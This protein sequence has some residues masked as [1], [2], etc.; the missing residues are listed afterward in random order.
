MDFD[1]LKPKQSFYRFGAERRGLNSTQFSLREP[2][3]DRESST[4]HGAR[5]ST[6]KWH[7][8][9]YYQK[10]S[11]WKN[12]VGIRTAEKVSVLVAL[13]STFFC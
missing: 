2:E 1:R 5:S 11:I 8:D 10:K 13:F 7:L 6:R 9:E 3:K 4:E 12:I